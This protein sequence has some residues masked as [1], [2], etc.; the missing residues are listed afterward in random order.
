VSTPEERV[1][2]SLLLTFDAH[3]AGQLEAFGRI[4]V[5]LHERARLAG[6]IVEADGNATERMKARGALEEVEQLLGLVDEQ[7]E[8]ARAARDA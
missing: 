3:A 5:V 8:F 7:I 2:E 1:H 6:E 4:R